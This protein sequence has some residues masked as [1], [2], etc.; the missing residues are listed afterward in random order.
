MEGLREWTPETG[1]P[2]GAVLSPLLANI[3][4]NPL[5]HL[6]TDAGFAMVRYA[7][8][9]VILC[10]TRED[11]EKALETMRH[12]VVENDLALHPTK[13]KIV[14]ADTEGFDFLGYHFRGK[15]RLPRDKSLKRFKDAVRDK[16]KRANG[17]SMPFFVRSVES[18]TPRMVRLLS[19][20]SL[21]HLPG[22][23]RVDTWS[24]AQHPAQAAA[25]PRPCPGQRPST[26]AEYL[27]R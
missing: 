7:D 19:S 9:F 2:Q 18:A 3:Y 24:P 13:T 4:L 11:A 14:D 1:T 15:L 21:A 16:T 22:F 8:D 25:P 17:L 12:W 6:L 10:R 5:D 27:L 20:L 23:G 26:V